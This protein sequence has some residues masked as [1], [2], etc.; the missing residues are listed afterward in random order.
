MHSL[1][2]AALEGTITG[3][4][5]HLVYCWVKNEQELSR[6]AEYLDFK[7][8]KYTGFREPDIGD[9]LTAIATEPLTD[10]KPL[11]KLKLV[12]E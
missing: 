7:G 11:K 12:K 8:I 10:R 1:L 9:Q 5:P 6:L 2:Q 4:H 3:P